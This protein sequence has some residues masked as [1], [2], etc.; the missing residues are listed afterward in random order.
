MT[1]RV[2]LFV[3]DPQNDF[4]ASGREPEGRRGALFVE[5]ADREAGR[6]R[7]MVLRLKSAGGHAIAKIH[8]TL[9]SHP[10]ND[11]SHHTA[12]ARPDGSSPP[13]FTLVTHD[14]VTAGRYTPRFPFGIWEGHVVTAREWASSYTGTLE[15]KGRAPLF[16]WPRHCEIGTWGQCVYG[17][18]REAFEDW[19]SAT[20][21]WV[22]FVTKGTW[23]FTEHYSG[24]RADVPDPTRS[25]TGLNV[26]VLDDLAGADVVAFLGWAGSHCLNWTV[27]DAV[28]HFGSGANEFARK[29][30][31]FEDA[32]AP[33]PDPPGSMAFAD[34]RMR[35]LDGMAARGATI[36]STDHFLR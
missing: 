7:D 24:L 34:A 21:G 6:V 14:D 3:I 20:V 32:S 36:T 25:E 28:D 16:L 8:A 11:C 10:Q 15:A 30:V 35:F 27:T 4:C 17:P 1:R 12:W 29:V 33:V 13:P 23:P 26:A 31:L 22:D 2:D 9:D 5:G 18:I 19:C